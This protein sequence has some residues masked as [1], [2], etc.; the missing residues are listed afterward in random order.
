MDGEWREGDLL[1]CVD[2]SAPRDFGRYCE[3]W[4]F[5]LPLHAHRTYTVAK[6][7]RKFPDIGFGISTTDDPATPW[8]FARFRKITPLEVDQFDQQIIS[9]MKGNHAPVGEGV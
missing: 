9:I 8:H 7:G 4:G 3:N 1:W 2:D 6:I 5:G